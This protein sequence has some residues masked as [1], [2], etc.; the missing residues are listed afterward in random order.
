MR[1]LF[2]TGG[3]LVVGVANSL[4]WQFAGP[5]EYNAN[6]L[7]DFSLVQPLLRAGGRAVVLEGLTEAER[8]LLANIRQM[9]RFRRG[10]YT[11]IVAGRSPGPGPALGGI[12]IGTT[13]TAANQTAAGYLGLLEDQVL[14]N[15]QR[16]NML[17]LRES[18]HRL[19]EFYDVGRISATQVGL[20][21]QQLYTAQSR[22]LQI[23][24]AY[25]STLDS[26]KITLGLP[27][28]VDMRIEDQLLNRFDLI[29]PATDGNA[30]QSDRSV[31]SSARPAA[32]PGV[33]RRPR[34]AATLAD[35]REDV[36]EELQMVADDLERWARPFPN[37]ARA[38]SCCWLAM[39]FA[40]ARS[41]AASATSAHSTCV[42]PP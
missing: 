32:A 23:T 28:E 4:V 33:L 7:L 3:E 27:P 34:D 38:C 22:L 26:Y 6:T 8:T 24:S 19:E 31:D 21:R 35:L 5:D 18:L 2:A 39:N 11:Q 30:D 1:K 40:A 15:N 9:E 14:I 42:W 13:I 17:G 20:T 25:E 41:N 10:F 29:D 16:A 36:A 12:R 37:A